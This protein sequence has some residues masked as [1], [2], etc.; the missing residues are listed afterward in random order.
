[1][2]EIRVPADHY[3]GAQ[4]QRALTHFSIGD[5]PIPKE[6]IKALAMIK[7]AAAI[8]NRDLGNLAED[9]AGLIIQV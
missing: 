4:T 1:M 3:W 8:T 5:D 2:G 7:K 9:K 6:V